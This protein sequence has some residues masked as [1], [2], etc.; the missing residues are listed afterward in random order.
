VDEVRIADLK[1]WLPEA[2]AQ[3]TGT[4]KALGS[5]VISGPAR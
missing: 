2:Q 3:A 4:G 5:S 1:K